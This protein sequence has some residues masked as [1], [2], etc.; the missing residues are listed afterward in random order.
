DVDGR[1]MKASHR[2]RGG[3]QVL[4][5]IPDP[6]PAMP[7]PEALPLEIVFEDKD[8]V[9]LNKAAGMVVHPGAGHAGGTLGNALLHRIADLQGVGGELR[10]GIVHRLDKETSGCLVVAKNGFTLERLQAAFQRREVEK[11]YLA[12]VHGQPPREKEIDTYFG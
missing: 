9:V 4:V 6:T 1:S 7:Q 10:P 5:R 3:E 11:R 2:V 12:I 8:L